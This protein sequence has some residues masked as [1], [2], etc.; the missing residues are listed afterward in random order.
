MKNNTPKFL[1]GGGEMGEIIRSKDWS[2]TSIG[3]PEQWPT[4]LK[5]TVGIILSS[6]FPMCIA[7]G[8]EYTQIYN[9]AYLP[10][11]GGNK[12]P[13]ALGISTRESFAETWTKTTGPMFDGVMKGK[14]VNFFN[15]KVNLERNGFLEECYFNFSNSPISD[16]NGNI[17]GVLVTVLETTEN[18]KLLESLNE[19]KQQLEIAKIETERQRDRLKRFFMEAPA[20]IC[21]LEGQELVFELINPTFQKLFP[22]RELLDKALLKVI[23]EILGQPIE[24]IIFDVY[25]NNKTFESKEL[26]IPLARTDNGILEDRYF[27]FIYQPKHNDNGKVDGILVFAFEVTNIVAIKLSVRESAVRFKSMIEQAPVPMLVTMGEEMI[28]EE[29][30]PPMLALLDRDISIMGLPLKEALPE[31]VGQPILEKL[32]EVYKTGKSWSGIEELV[33]LDRNGK[34]EERYFNVSYTSFVENG[35]ITGVLQSAIDVT[36]Q[37]MARRNLEKAEDTL[38]LA[39]SAAKL[40]TFDMDLEKDTLEWDPRCRKLFGISHNYQ[41]SFKHDFI[42]AL[43]PDD[44]ERVLKVIDEVF[45]K[46]VSNGRYNSEYRT[47]G[48]EDK[49]IRW[50]RA[51]GKA[52]FNQ[53]DKPIRFIGSVLDITELKQDELRKNDFIGMVSHELKTPLTT[54]NGYSQILQ[55]KAKK[56][57]DEYC[58]DV[59]SKMVVQVKKM[60]TMINGFLNVSRLESGKIYLDKQQFDF[61]K[62]LNE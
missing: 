13:Q 15:F 36:E 53:Q 33:F 43:H 28:L 60:S 59:L 11:L 27:N 4:E 52:Y 45:I 55:L 42:N 40:G 54:L 34:N 10:I 21:V 3:V 41:V 31:L 9:T 35:E 12:H 47:V 23:P 14:A 16:E 6:S 39:I 30:N 25:N 17:G 62:L 51:M 8:K 37:V 32:L 7:W 5:I 57:G 44:R 20:G 50:V 26:L 19:T 48:F 29:I 24:K 56:N 2:K 18:V 22:G 1:K 49:R 58:A 46:S 38:K 61:N